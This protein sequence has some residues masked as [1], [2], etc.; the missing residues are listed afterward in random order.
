MSFLYQNNRSTGSIEGAI[1]HKDSMER[2]GANAC[3]TG[4]ETIL[5]YKM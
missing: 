3:L 4:K 2:P 5:K 1:G